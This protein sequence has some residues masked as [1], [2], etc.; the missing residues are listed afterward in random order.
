MQRAQDWLREGQAELQAARSLFEEGHWSWCCF[1][2]QQ[3][4]EKALKAVC[5]HLRSPQFGH[6]LNVLVQAVAAHVAVP[7]S[8]STA[9]ARLNRHYIPTRYP[10]AFDRGAPADQ[11]FE[12]D[13]QQALEDGSEVISFAEGVVGPPG[14]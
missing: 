8:V 6:N 11:F 4:A 5:E 10:N 12:P 14:D 9:C 13:A 2:S 1:T 7:P 3:A